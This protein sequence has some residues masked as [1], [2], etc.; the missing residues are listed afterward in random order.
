MTDLPG[1]LPVAPTGQAGTADNAAQ[2]Q[3]GGPAPGP[4]AP[5]A[6]R[7]GRSV[8]SAVLGF[9]NQLHQW[10]TRRGDEAGAARL[11]AEAGRF[12]ETALWVVVAGDV[13]RGKSS[14]LNAMLDRPGLL[15]VD[16]DVA[17]SVHLVVRGGDADTAAV[18]VLDDD[19]APQRRTIDPAELAAYAS[20]QADEVLRSRVADVE[21]TLVNPLLQRGIVLVD[22]PGVGGMSRGHKDMTMAALAR[23]DVLLFT[24]SSEEPVSRTELEFLAEASARID[25]VVFALTKTDL[26]ADDVNAAME[27]DDRERLRTRHAALERRAAEGDEEAASAAGRFARLSTAPF[28][29]TSA[30]LAERAATR[31]AAGR[32]ET[33]ARFRER[34]GLDVLEHVLEASIDRREDLRLANVLHLADTLVADAAAAETAR[35]RACEGDSGAEADLLAQRGELEA[36]MS[37]QAKWRSTLNTGIQRMQTETGRKVSHELNLIKTHYRELLEETKTVDKVGETLPEELE[38]SLQAAWNNLTAQANE[39][40]ARM[41]GT[42]FE[43]F[44]VS[45]LD[46][47]LG[48]MR[49]PEGIDDAVAQSRDATKSEVTLLDDGVPL[50]TQTFS[51]AATINAA[52]GAVGLAT[53]GLGLVAYGIGAGLSFMISKMRHKHRGRL[54]SRAE[55][56]RVISEALFGAEGIAKEFSTELGLRILDARERVEHLVDERLTE[57]RKALEVRGQELQ[58]LLRAEAGERAKVAQQAQAALKEIEALRGEIARLRQALSKRSRPEPAPPPPDATPT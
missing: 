49:R 10:L 21:V 40:F 55:Y 26:A 12:K 2:V 43:E 54:Q 7:R 46:A 13:K 6:G 50:A 53:G 22:T 48:E 38:R 52:A 4:A 20:M 39:D 57:R 8:S 15:P 33:A 27:A 16:A 9:G 23:A 45:A 5:P 37:R 35:L 25:Q 41:L 31:A 18:T 44:D 1:D 36:F 11:A 3:V 56:N 47:V 32:A 28:V 24:I 14:L 34:S 58:R 42:F 51:F 29:G 30:F 19:G 17:T